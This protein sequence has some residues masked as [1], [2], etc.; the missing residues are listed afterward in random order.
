MV[1]RLAERM[2][3]TPEDTDGWIMLARSYTVLGRFADAVP[4][5]RYSPAFVQERLLKAAT[6]DEAHALFAAVAEEAE[7][8]VLRAA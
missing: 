7:V 5:G 4:A 3:T 2:R 8:A 6:V 1:G